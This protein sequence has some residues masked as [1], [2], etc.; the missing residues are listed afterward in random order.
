MFGFIGKFK[1][2]V[3]SGFDSIHTRL[4]TL[5]AKV[6]ALFNHNK[7]IAEAAVKKDVGVVEAAGAAVEQSVKDATTPTN[8]GTT[9]GTGA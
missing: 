3:L 4:V 5:E 8:N 9:P 2:E 7:V 1:D 6:E